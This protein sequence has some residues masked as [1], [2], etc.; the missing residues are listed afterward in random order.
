M[1]QQRRGG[2]SLC[3]RVARMVMRD[4]GLILTVLSPTVPVSDRIESG[5]ARLVRE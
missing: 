5:M 3:T 1:D 4:G 2:S